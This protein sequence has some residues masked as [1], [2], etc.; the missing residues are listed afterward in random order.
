MAVDNFLEDLW[1]DAVET[2][3]LAQQIVIPTVNGKYT[4]EVTQGAK[5]KITGAVTPTISDYA[6][7]RTATPEAL[8]DDGQDL[9]IDQ[10]DSWS[11]ILD[12]IDKIQAAG[13]LMEW[14]ASAGAALAE[15]SEQYIID[16]IKSQSWTLNVTGASPLTIDS[17]ED[18]KLALL[19]TREHL[20]KKKIPNSNRFAVV[21]PE[22][23]SYLLDGLSDVSVSGGND[24]LR[25][26]FV[27]RMYGFTILE[28]PLV[29]EAGKP[30]VL[31]YHSNT[32]A[33]VNQL[34]ETETLRHQTKF[35]DIV[36]GLNV[37]GG[38][39]VRQ[40]GVS[41]FVSGGASQN[42]FSSFLS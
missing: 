22:F 40:V 2:E 12:D 15:T 37:Y 38:K 36:R 33:Y 18:A 34:Q 31:A 41:S 23:A 9:L 6:S 14:A 20:T 32:V 3:F 30:T 35:G 29:G 11:I 7:T 1:T 16:Q 24:E 4:G 25:N 5:I 21:N 39:V 26:G 19:R 17:Y 27:A 28:S 8:N 10:A 42:A 13:D